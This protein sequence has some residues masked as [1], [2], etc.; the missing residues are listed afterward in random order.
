LSAP[1]LA[2]ELLAALAPVLA[3]FGARWYLFG[4][5]A[6]I[7]WGRP[8]FTGDVDVTVEIRDDQVKPLIAA[9]SAAGFDLRLPGGVDAFVARTRV[10][11]FLYTPTRIPLD[12]VVAGPGLEKEFLDRAQRVDLGAVEV[13][14]L[15]PED[16]VITKVLAARP[17][18][19]DDVEGILRERAAELDLDRIRHTLG[20]LEHAIGQSDLIPA[21]ERALSRAPRGS[22][23]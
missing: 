6:V 1:L 16:L 8:R 5:Q 21:F 18:D 2:T 4:A 9:M 14:V 19:L 7:V 17:K 11:P 22:A 15:S 20:L 23:G 13:P 10:L 12:V 3:R